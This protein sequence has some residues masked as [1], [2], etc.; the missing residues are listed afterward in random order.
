M[1]ATSKS[2]TSDGANLTRH[3]VARMSQRGIPTE[4]I[5][6]VLYFGRVVFIRGAVIHAIGRKE[7]ERFRANNIDLSDCEGIQVV[8]SMD[9]AVITAY[10]NDDFRSLRTDRPRSKIRPPKYLRRCTAVD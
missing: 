9:G 5:T 3:A 2:K 6:L 7:V 4:M 8:C 1:H 10:R